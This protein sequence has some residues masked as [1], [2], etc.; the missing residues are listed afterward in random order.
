M[1]FLGAL[2]R[3]RVERVIGFTYERSQAAE[4]AA[5]ETERS[6][7]ERS[8]GAGAARFH[9]FQFGPNKSEVHWIRIFSA[10]VCLSAGGP[11]SPQDRTSICCL[12][13]RRA[14]TED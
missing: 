6:H 3:A 13:L 14:I 8:G 4:R 10:H 7:A 12:K 1:R 11:C 9:D 2:R 5:P